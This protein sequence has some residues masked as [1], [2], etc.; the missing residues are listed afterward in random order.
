MK[1]YP[2]MSYWQTETGRFDEDSCSFINRKLSEV[3][4]KEIYIEYD[5][6]T[7][8]L[9]FRGGPTGYESYY[10]TSLESS[11]LTSESD[12]FCICGGTINSWPI[13]TVKMENF[14]DI[15]NEIKKERKH[16]N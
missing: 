12:K 10:F 13:C 8:I 11:I 7:D 3:K 9:Y 6:E 1:K 2:I 4:E 16:V 15:F 14:R 5:Q